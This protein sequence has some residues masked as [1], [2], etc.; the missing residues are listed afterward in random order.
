MWKLVALLVSLLL[1]TEVSGI[2]QALFS[3]NHIVGKQRLIPEEDYITIMSSI[4]LDELYA[5]VDQHPQ[6]LDELKD[7]VDRN[8]ASCEL[9]YVR[10]S[11]LADANL[12]E[13]LCSPRGRERKWVDN[14]FLKKW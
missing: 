4:Y 13:Y 8:L 1:V 3:C 11:A 5:L 9:P 12:L 2:C 14:F 7:C 10:D 6:L